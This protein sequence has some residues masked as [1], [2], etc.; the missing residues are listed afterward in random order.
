ML[1][2]HTRSALRAL[3]ATAL[4]STAGHLAAQPAPAAAPQ[5]DL[6]HARS[7]ANETIIVTGVRRDVNDVL[8]GVSVLGGAELANAIRPSIGETL[9]KQPGVSATSFGPAASRPILRGLGGDRIRIL[10]DGIGSLDL[11]ASSADHAVAINPLTADRIEILRGPSALLFGSAAI[12]GVV[13][14]I[15]SR[16]PRRDPERPAH[17]EGLLGYGSAANERLANLAV[18]VP[19]GSGIVLHAD[20]SWAKSDE[21]RTGGFILSKPFRAEARASDDPAINALADLKGDL[22]NSAAK[23]AEVAGAIGYVKGALNFGVSVTRHTALYGVP[24]RYSLDPEVEA[25]APRIDVEQTRYDARAEL[26][27]SGA[28]ANLR[29]R[30]GLAR[31]H[32]DELEPDGE[33]GTSF[34]TRGGELRAELEQAERSGW[35]GT[36]GL[37][38]LQKSV[39][40]EGEEKYLPDAR[41]RQSGI[42]TLQ[43]LKMDRW[44]FEGGVRLETSRLTAEAD[45]LLGTP[46]G[47][48]RFTTFSGSLGALYELSPGWRAGLNLSRSARAPAIDELFAG[49]PHAGTQAFEIGDPTL[50]AERSI[51]IEASLRR[52]AGPVRAT[53][54]AF[55]TRFGNFIYQS[56]TGEIEDDLPVLAYRQGKARYRGLEAEV[57]AKLGKFGSIDWGL[58][59]QA[60]AVRATIVNEGPA[61]FIPPVRLLGAV[62]AERGNFDGRIEVEHARRVT[63]TADRETP[64]PGYT[65]VNAEIEWHPLERRPSFALALA[66]NNIFDVEARRHSSLLKD[67]A[68]LAG[69]DVRLTA[70]FDF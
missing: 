31:Y 29:V 21:L 6:R 53:L 55:V 8:G 35:G 60:D 14:V 15:D 3:L 26:P 48:R 62:T 10:T 45:E 57:E 46:E 42:F 28:F 27:L 61:P 47:R 63:R 19:L 4:V 51:G 17:A 70:R 69:R 5:D 59:L 41:Q 52:T 39:S 16:I 40:I 56:P 43:S 22:P 65:L 33:I 49:G 12:G 67:F 36:S 58:E 20:G 68:P 30:G 64:T 18:D 24:I 7:H 34:Y 66:A 11:S 9:A 1:S 37:Q 23:S 54:T 38:F 44:R 50:D 2:F 32:H 13:N 25:E